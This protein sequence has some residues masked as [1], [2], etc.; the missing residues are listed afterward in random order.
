MIGQQRWLYQTTPHEGMTGNPKR[1]SIHHISSKTTG[2]RL[3][4]RGAL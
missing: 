2:G 1:H 3:D 4:F